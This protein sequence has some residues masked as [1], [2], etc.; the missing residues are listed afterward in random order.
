MPLL[1]GF[2]LLSTV[3]IYLVTGLAVAEMGLNWPAVFFG[4]IAALDWRAQF[5][6]DF[7]VHLV[8]L[9]TWIWWREGSTVRGFVFGFLSIFMG[10]MF[11]F[12]Y[13]LLAILGAKGDPVRVLLGVHAD[14]IPNRVEA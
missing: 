8:L 2:L 12:P 9:A 6:V 7:L 4:D 5:N 10:G 3:L 14:P 13:L 11:G 1:K